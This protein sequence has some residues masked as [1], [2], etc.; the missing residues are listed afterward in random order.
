MINRVV[1]GLL[2]VTCV[3]VAWRST[4]LKPKQ[5]A[6][7]EQISFTQTDTSSEVTENAVPAKP[8]QADDAPELIDRLDKIEQ[9]LA[10]L[11]SELAEVKD[12]QLYS[13]VPA[14]SSTSEEEKDSSPVASVQERHAYLDSLLE[15]TRNEDVEWSTKTTAKIDEAVQSDPLLSKAEHF[16][17]DCAETLCKIETLV[18]AALDGFQEQEFQWTMLAAVGQELPTATFQMEHLPDGSKRMVFYMGR[19]GYLLPRPGE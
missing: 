6:D 1:I 9:V 7:A 2:L 17:V 5:V 13:E 18:P 4:G 8:M 15:T 14:D 19:E 12:R 10:Q 3:F 11:A 16:V